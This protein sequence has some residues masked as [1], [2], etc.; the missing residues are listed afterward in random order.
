VRF[1]TL[2]DAATAQ[3]LDARWLRDTLA[4]VSSYGARAFE[5]LEPYLPGDEARAQAGADAVMRVVRSIEGAK[6][7][8]ARDVMRRA[9]DVS[10]A[11]ARAS[12]GDILDDPS[13]LELQRFFD[14]CEQLD[15][16]TRDA[17]DIPRAASEAV[18]ACA[19]ALERGRS[20]KFGFY[21]DSAFDVS[22][23]NER[24]S[25][26]AAQA[27]YDAVRGRQTA[28]IARELGREI[29]GHEFIVMRD[30]AP[31]AL[32][33]GVRVVREAPTYVLCEL[34]AD[35]AVLGAIARRDAA[36]ARV[37]LA[38][39]NV[40]GALSAIVRDRAAALGE[41]CASFAQADWTIAQAR[42]A[43]QFTCVAP[44]LSAESALELHDARFVPLAA[45]LER[46][47]RAFTPISLS[48]P[49]VAV[50]TGPN[51]G[52]KSVC[53][54]TCGLI[55]LCAAFGVPVPAARASL[56]LFAH[57]AWLGV[58]ADDAQGGLLSAFAREV[59]RLRDV[60]ER[61]AHPRLVLMDEFARTTTPRE[62]KALVVAIVR[63][64]QRDRAIGLVA[65]HVDGVATAAGARHY[66][67]RGLRHVPPQT[68]RGDLNGALAALAASMDYTLEE[69]SGDGRTG[70]DAIALA[71]LLGTDAALIEDAYAALDSP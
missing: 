25:L 47:G 27:E 36:A 13:F 70:A 49:G 53:L 16:L 54:R 45:Q 56:P 61:D 5:V 26:A 28:A 11:V 14:A 68:A 71:A 50:L 55:A 12:M 22:L 69:V 51:M 67:V 15:S 1:A 2:L 43:L 63:R 62:G 60:L 9:P 59:V 4:P 57:I 65:T 8:A 17:V 31:A 18:R 35:E 32:P 52:G 64:L 21:L 38:E 33:A 44:D 24:G 39:S 46:Q 10:S 23:A 48:L 34:D 7:D 37:A 66:A 41:A 6:L 3:S 42:F 30:G 19:R 29:D 20:G 40:R 58:G